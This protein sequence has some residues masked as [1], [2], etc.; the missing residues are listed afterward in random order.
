VGS[1]EWWDAVESGKIPKM[2]V[3]GKICLI[4]IMLG[5]C[6]DKLMHIYKGKLYPR[7]ENKRPFL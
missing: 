1:L 5:N 4:I 6:G 7:A 3:Q 2:F